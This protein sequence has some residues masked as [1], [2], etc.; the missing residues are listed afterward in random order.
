MNGRLTGRPGV[1]EDPYPTCLNPS[2]SRVDF[3]GIR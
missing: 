3:V 2:L 1:V